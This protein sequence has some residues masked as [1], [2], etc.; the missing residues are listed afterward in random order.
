M[1]W[2]D[3]LDGMFHN[4]IHMELIFDCT[5]H[6]QRFKWGWLIK[7]L[8]NSPKLQT[9][10]IEEYDDTIH[11]YADQE[12]KDPEFV[13]ECFL[14]HLTTCSLRNY[15]SANCRMQFAKY[16]MQINSRV[17]STMTIQIAKSVKSSTKIQMCKELSLCPTNSATCKLLFI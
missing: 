14:S 11:N 9:M 12:W 16:I 7:L 15:T 8:Q 6:S 17:L 3:C 5:Y 13:P 10:I 2:F 4:L 1:Q